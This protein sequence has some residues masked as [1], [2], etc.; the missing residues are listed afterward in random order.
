MKASHRAKP[1]METSDI[2]GYIDP[3]ISYPGDKPAVKVSCSRSTFTSRVYRLGAGYKHLDAPPVSHQLVSEIPQQ[4]HRGTPQFSRIGSFARV[5]SWVR[6][7][8]DAVDSMSIS[9]WCQA[10]LPTG[11]GHDQYLFSSIDIEHMTG[12][13]CLL[14]EDGN[15]FL[16]V[17]GSAEV[18]QVRFS[19]KFV[20]HQWYHLHFV[21]EPG[22]GVVKLN[23]QAKA[24]DIGEQS[25]FFTEEYQLP[26]AAR[27]AS[28]RPF[29]IASNS[30]QCGPSSKPENSCSF[31]G[32]IDGFKLL[33]RSK[34]NTHILLDFDFSLDIPT[35]KIR[36]KSKGL[37]GE[38]IN[39]PSRA[40]TS[41]DWDASQSDW[42]CASY[43]YGAIHFHDDDLDDAMWDTSFKLEL[44]RH[45]WSGCYAVFVDDGETTDFIPFFVKPNPDAEEIP[46]VALVI[47]TF[48][49]AG[50]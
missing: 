49:Y 24:G 14:D 5:K 29:T 31:N 11:A 33:T 27:I 36:D 37:C 47:P 48:T 20:R 46:P 50:K 28:K 22:N 44:P 19:I 15:L 21:V 4:T 26:Q 23:V 12:F 38:L 32:K 34:E 42:T 43:G 18:Q 13:E 2:V 16:H 17:G 40:V 45:L 3:L 41:H 7:D 1:L 10:T 9:F 6:S 25:A 35:D 30:R 39:G 8:L